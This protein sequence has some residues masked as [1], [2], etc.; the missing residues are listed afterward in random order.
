MAALV[1][2]ILMFATKWFGV[3][4]V[5]DP[6]AA[7]PAVS[8]SEDAW[9]GLTDLRWLMLLTILVALGSVALHASQRAHGSRTDTSWV[10]CGL[11][12]VTALL[13]AYRVLVHLPQPDR[14]LDQK[15]G[16]VLGLI[17]AL[18]IAIGGLESVTEQQLRAAAEPEPA[19]RRRPAAPRQP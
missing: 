7:R 5:V 16:A 11:G 6:S 15:L 12:S 9:S 2:L 1:L 4:G 3:A 13:L 14:V 8:T 18:G 10:V 17:C 19:H